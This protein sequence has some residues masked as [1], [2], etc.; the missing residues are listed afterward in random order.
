[1]PALVRAG[2]C[3]RTTSSK[4][5]LSQSRCTTIWCH[6]PPILPVVQLCTMIYAV[7]Q[8]HCAR[9]SHLRCQWL[10]MAAAMLRARRD[11]RHSV[12][13]VCSPCRRR[14]IGDWSRLWQCWAS[15][16]SVL[17]KRGMRGAVCAPLRRVTSSAVGAF[18]IV[19]GGRPCGR[20]AEDAAKSEQQCKQL[21]CK[22][23]HGVGVST[24]VWQVALTTT[25]K[26][27]KLCS[28]HSTIF[29]LSLN[30]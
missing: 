25:M 14:P 28:G 3:A 9:S 4:D 20:Q 12:D 11:L 16:L 2:H 22:E 13:A 19:V 21:Q 17:H 23:V 29:D 18:T 5:M 26:C 27:S 10:A 6:Q 8:L 1:M 24:R 30:C 7:K 15:A